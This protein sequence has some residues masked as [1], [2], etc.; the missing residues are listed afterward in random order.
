MQ[1]F[2]IEKLKYEFTLDKQESNHI[3][4]VLRKK[5]GDTL[6]FT[7]GKGN[8]YSSKITSIDK[9]KCKVVIIDSKKKEKLHQGHLHIVIAPTKNMSRFEWFLEKSTEI[10]IDEITPVICSK[11]ERKTINHERCNKIIISAMKQSVKFHLP[12][13][14]YLANFNDI[15]NINFNATKYIAHCQSYKRELLEKQKFHENTMILIGPEG[16][17]SED[18]IQ[19]AIEK[20]YKSIS[21]GKSRLRTDTAGVKASII[22]SIL[23]K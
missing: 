15:I 12:K 20:N 23:I 7:D 2:Y 5:E 13:L 16:D 19:K 9:K 22:N 8:L 1:L 18:E 21:L 14:N 4:K 3:V 10:G 17:F 11:S 6:L